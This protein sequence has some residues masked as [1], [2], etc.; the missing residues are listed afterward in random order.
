[1]FV[2]LCYRIKL[3]VLVSCPVNVVCDNVGHRA[4]GSILYRD[5]WVDLD[6]LF[7]VGHEMIEWHSLGFGNG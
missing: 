1:M 6:Y 3:G 5:V 4:S 7:D 2:E